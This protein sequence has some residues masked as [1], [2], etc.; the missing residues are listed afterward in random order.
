MTRLVLTNAIYFKASWQTPF[1]PSATRDADFHLL[2]GD[3]VTAPM[4]HSQGA[5]SLQYAEG[6]D[7]QAVELPYTG[8][9]VSM[10]LILPAESAFESFEAA[11]DDQK[12]SAIVDAL[13]TE[14]VSVA[15][16]RFEFSSDVP[17]K[18]TLIELGMPTAF[19][20]G[21][22]DFSG[23]DGTR[24]LYIQDVLHKA[25]VAVDEEG[26]EA[27]AATAVIVGETSAPAE[28]K[29]FEA[30]R[31]FLFLIRDDVTGTVLFL[32]RV[33]NPNE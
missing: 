18:D 10:L 21:A 20:G 25:F 30:N 13:A 22:A 28:P 15:L 24:N 29:T 7:W 16:P 4:M 23:I 6:D 9:Q 32:G 8:N 12:L 27:A 5:E 26:T 19:E 17:L 14:N 11:F 2:S 1:E 31:P 3:T 33:L